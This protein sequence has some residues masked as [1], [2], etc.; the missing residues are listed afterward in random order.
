MHL[1]MPV[2]MLRYVEYVDDDATPDDDGDIVV[3]VCCVMMM[4]PLLV[5]M[6]YPRYTDSRYLCIAYCRYMR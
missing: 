1:L 6:L 4:L 5:L 3:I 2:L